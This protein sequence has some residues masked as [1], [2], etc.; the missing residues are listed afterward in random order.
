M[1]LRISILIALA[2]GSLAGAPVFI[3]FQINDSYV[4][5][6]AV[7]NVSIGVAAA[8]DGPFVAQGTTDAD[9]RLRLSLEPGDYF[10]NYE[11]QGYVP[12]RKSPIRWVPSL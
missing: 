11:A 8:E 9:G 10:V 2:A 5:D 4:K 3:T 7:A 1:A 6:K 12:I